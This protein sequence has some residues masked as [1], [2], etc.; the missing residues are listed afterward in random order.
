MRRTDANEFYDLAAK[1]VDSKRE[2]TKLWWRIFFEIIVR[3]LYT[4]G[5][6]YLPMIGYM[7]LEHVEGG[8]QKQVDSKGF[9]HWYDVPDK[10][11]PVFLPEEDFVNDINMKGVTKGYRQREKMNKF[12]LRDRERQRRLQEIIG[13]EYEEIPEKQLQEQAQFIDEFDELMK[14]KRQIYEQK[15]EEILKETSDDTE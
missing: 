4:S 7:R 14:Q 8:I 9:V 5:V 15:L 11:K 10:D 13:E 3:E 12:T 2:K 1:L 6:V